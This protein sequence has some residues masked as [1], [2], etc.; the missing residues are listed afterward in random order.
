MTSEPSS[1]TSLRKYYKIS[2]HQIEPRD[3]VTNLKNESDRSL[4]V[5]WVSVLE[6]ALTLEIKKKFRAMEEKEEKALRL[7]LPEGPIGSFSL[8]INVSYAM[9]IIDEPTRQSLTDIREMRNACA[10]SFKPIGFETKELVTV[11]KRVFGDDRDSLITMPPDD[12]ATDLLRD[13]F[14]YQCIALLMTITHG[15]RDAA[16]EVITGL[17]EEDQKRPRAT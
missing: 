11:F 12:A 5:V 15:S 17:I 8:K 16:R 3:L 7:Y 14:S 1:Y 4:V 2:Y 9:Q 10:H 6:D 13:T